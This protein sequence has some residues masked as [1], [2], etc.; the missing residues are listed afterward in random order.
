LAAGD[1]QQF[2]DPLVAHQFAAKAEVLR[3]ALPTSRLPDAS[4][5]VHGIDDGAALWDRQRQRF[6]AVDVLARPDAGQGQQGVPV[7]R[8]RDAERVDIG[9]LQ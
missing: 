5:A 1:A 7:V 4:V 3:R 9:P 2:A 6:F 8:D